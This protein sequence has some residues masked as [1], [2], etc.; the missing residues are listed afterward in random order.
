VV[1]CEIKHLKLFQNNFILHVT[2]A[3]GMF[4]FLVICAA[5]VAMATKAAYERVC[6][7]GYVDPMLLRTSTLE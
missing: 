3:L 1:T 6:D 5:C 7:S 4:P 2:T